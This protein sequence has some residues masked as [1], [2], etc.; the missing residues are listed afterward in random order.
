MVTASSLLPALK[1]IAAKRGAKPSCRRAR[2]PDQ[3]G[4][5]EGQEVLDV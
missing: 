2:F 3:P 1:V 4:G 5:Q